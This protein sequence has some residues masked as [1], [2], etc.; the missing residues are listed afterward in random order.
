[1]TLDEVISLK[2][3][4][5]SELTMPAAGFRLM[6][7]RIDAGLTNKFVQSLVARPLRELPMIF[8]TS[9]PGLVGAALRGRSLTSNLLAT[10]QTLSAQGADDDAASPRLSVGY[11]EVAAKRYRVEVRIQRPSV[12]TVLLAQEVARRANGE[13][14]IGEYRQLK[15]HA[16][17][18]LLGGSVG[19]KKSP[20]GTLGLFLSSSDG[21]GIV[22]NSHVLAWC[23]RARRGDPIYAPHPKDAKEVRE[24]AILH[25]FNS[26]IEDHEVSLDAAFALLND[27]IQH[28]ENVIPEGFPQAGK[29]LAMTKVMPANLD[30]RVCKIG[31]TSKYTM[32][33]LSAVA[34]SATLDYPGLGD[35]K[36]TGMLEVQ[37]ESL[38]KEF[39][40]PGDSGSVVYRPDTMEALAIVVGGGVR[41]VEGKREGVSIVCPLD[42]IMKE[43]NLTFV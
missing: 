12:H 16:G 4:V 8:G 5:E 39:S 21:V 32:G 35:V 40:Q 18:L 7:N 2:Q 10:A 29:R 33:A 30:L 36:L 14:R 3:E 27:G 6:Q 38:E 31:R 37:W 1:M 26:L 17:G 28:P 13:A 15:S 19:H 22:S 41:E 24:I 42:V 23:G 20:P 25:R 11:S 9:A 34:V 43:W